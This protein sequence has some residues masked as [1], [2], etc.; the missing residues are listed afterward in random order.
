MVSSK[1]VAIVTGGGQ[2]IGRAS[3]ERLAADGFAVVIG[4]IDPQAGAAAVTSIKD[5]GGAAQFVV[6]DASQLDQ[7]VGLAETAVAAYGDLNVIVANAGVA[8]VRSV[9]DTTEA[10]LARLFS[11]NVNGVVW[12]IQA[13]TTQARALGHGGKIIVAGSAASYKGFPAQGAYSATKFAVRGLIQSAAQELAVDDITI[14]GYAPGIVDTGMWAQIDAE[15]G[16]MNGK[17]AGQNFRDSIKNSALGRPE[18]PEDV[19]K[20]VSFLASGDSDFMTGQL[21][22][23]DGGIV[24]G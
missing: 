12:A 24:F 7:V 22:I 3:A 19:A 11:V 8:R 9:L 18:T 21:V 16:A 13:F 17:S 1:K 4:D 15:L 10:D 14:N 20:V 23:V 5:A 2:G 6:A